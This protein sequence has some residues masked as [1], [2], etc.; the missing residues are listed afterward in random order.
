MADEQLQLESWCRDRLS[1]MVSKGRLRWVP[2]RNYHLT[3]AFL[4]QVLPSAAVN[5]MEAIQQAWSTRSIGTNSCSL[6]PSDE[7]IEG[8]PKQTRAKVIALKLEDEPWL[9]E[10]VHVVQVQCLETGL[11]KPELRQ[12]IPHVSFLRSSSPMNVREQLEY[13]S[14][15]K[16]LNVE[17]KSPPTLQFKEVTL[18][19]SK[20]SEVKGAPP[21]YTPLRTFDLLNK[22]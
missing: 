13:L 2:H 3:I 11:G 4:G 18:F 21:V 1:G 14:S 6:S 8:L 16:D 22:K 5:C 15:Q 9:K 12:F 20:N 10:L 17:L 7:P 19:Q